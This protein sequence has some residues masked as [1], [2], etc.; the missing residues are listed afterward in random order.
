[1]THIPYDR[2]DRFDSE[3]WLKGESEERIFRNVLTS[4]LYIKTLM[5]W[6]PASDKQIT[7]SSAQRRRWIY[8]IWT[9]TSCVSL[10]AFCLIMIMGG[11]IFLILLFSCLLLIF[12]IVGTTLAILRS[13]KSRYA[14]NGTESI[15]R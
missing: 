13:D 11:D 12:G 6:R 5:I 8:E 1:M 15:F 14:G 2:L 7:P 3:D 10:I 9:Y 4:Q